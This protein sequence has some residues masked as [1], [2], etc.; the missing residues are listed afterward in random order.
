MWHYALGYGVARQ[1]ASCDFLLTYA[2]IGYRCFSGSPQGGP[3]F[4]LWSILVM[5]LRCSV[6]AAVLVVLV[7]PAAGVLNKYVLVII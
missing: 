5:V 1:Q 6:R 2:C 4:Y 3:L 7:G